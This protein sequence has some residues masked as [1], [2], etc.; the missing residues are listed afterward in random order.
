MPPSSCNWIVVF[1]FLSIFTL[2]F[3]FLSLI[4]TQ[5]SFVLTL[6]VS[7]LEMM[8]WVLI[9]WFGLQNEV[10]KCPWT[11]PSY[12]VGFQVKFLMGFISFVSFREGSL[13]SWPAWVT[14]TCHF[15]GKWW[16]FWTL[17]WIHFYLWQYFAGW[18]F[19]FLCV[20]SCNFLIFFHLCSWTYFFPIFNQT[21]F[22]PFWL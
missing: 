1:R 21:R 6:F 7:L 20:L 9:D 11:S 8:G 3:R 13:K 12:F 4:Y 15:F 5:R 17:S 22:W 19:R 2:S 14:F 16:L 10:G 18:H